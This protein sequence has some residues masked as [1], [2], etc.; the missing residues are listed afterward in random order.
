MPTLGVVNTM[1]RTREQDVILKKHGIYENIRNL[2]QLTPKEM[3]EVKNATVMLKLGGYGLVGGI[4][5]AA[6]GSPEIGCLSILG[7]Y[8]VGAAGLIKNEKVYDLAEDRFIDKL[9]GQS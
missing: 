4:A 3:D 1:I 5:I 6:T 9:E 8:L 2:I 7:G